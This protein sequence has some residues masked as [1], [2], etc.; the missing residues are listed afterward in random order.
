[1]HEAC[2]L[3]FKVTSGFKP[4][5]AC[6]VIAALNAVNP[7]Y[8]QLP[9][10]NMGQ[11]VHQPGDNQYTNQTQAERHGAVMVPASSAV[12]PAAAPSSPNV[13]YRPTP[14]APKPDISLLPIVADEPIKPA[15]FPPLPDRLDLPDTRCWCLDKQWWTGI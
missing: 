8:A 14:A 1:M 2:T 13:A 7:V 10:T 6:T 15:G 3:I 4:L 12:A 11:F 5:I 9:P